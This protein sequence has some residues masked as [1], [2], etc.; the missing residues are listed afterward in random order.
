MLRIA[1]P[2]K[3]SL[4]E[5]SA[6]ALKE[7]GY[8]QRNDARDLVFID[9]DNSVEF[10]YLRPRDIAVYV[11][12]GELEAGI[13]GR[14]L[15]LDSGAGAS[16]VL[17]LDFGKSTFRFAAPTGLN[18]AISDLQ[19]KRI[20]T[21]YPQLVKQFLQSN[22]VQASIHE[23]SGSV[24]IA[25][26]IG[27]A[28]VVADLV[29]SGGTLFMNGLKEVEVILDSQAVLVAN[30]KIDADKKEIVGFDS[31]WIQRESEAKDLAE[32]MTNQWSKQQKVVSIETF[33]NPIVQIGDVVEVSYPNNDLYSSEDSS[34][35][36]GS[37]ANRFVVLSINGAYDKDSPPTTSLECRSI[38]I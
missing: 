14:D 7:A 4:A 1:V 24:E 6:L 28:D 8:R 33:L 34:T 15:L 37:A 3:G 20:A 13:T 35:P 17:P 27:L 36:L 10:Y 21:S 30:S 38:Y 29:S 12:S 26:G 32:W 18:M 11:G 25:P 16:E 9:P 22:N 2:N 23:I 19:G 5:I 31:T